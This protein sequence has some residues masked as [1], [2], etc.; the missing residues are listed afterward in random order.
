MMASGTSL[1]CIKHNAM[2][3]TWQPMKASMYMRVYIYTWQWR[4]TAVCSKT[5]TKTDASSD[6]YLLCPGRA[7]KMS[8]QVKFTCI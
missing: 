2:T 6:T 8:K 7:S 1:V 3:L 4:I 5:T